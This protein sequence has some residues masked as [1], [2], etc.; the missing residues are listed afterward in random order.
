VSRD[1]ISSGRIPICIE[2]SAV[3]AARLAA[4]TA[5]NVA[6]AR[7]SVPNA[8]ANEAAVDQ[9]HTQHNLPNGCPRRHPY[10]RDPGPNTSARDPAR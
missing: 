8:V 7:T 9:S 2:Y 10:K 4:R 3:R 1:G 5:T 6:R